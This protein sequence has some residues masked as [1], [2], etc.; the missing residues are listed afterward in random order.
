MTHA[1][2]LAEE[3]YPGVQPIGIQ[4]LERKAF[5]SGWE[6]SEVEIIGFAEWLDEHTAGS[7]NGTWLSIWDKLPD[8]L[9]TAELLNIYRNEIEKS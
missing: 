1:E 9:T 4:P 7:Q 5:I 8:G 6:A 3:R 2:K